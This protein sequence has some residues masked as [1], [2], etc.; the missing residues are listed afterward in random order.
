VTHFGV[1]PRDLA[2]AVSIHPVD[3]FA[4]T[5]EPY[6][7]AADQ[8]LRIDLLRENNRHSVARILRGLPWLGFDGFDST[9]LAFLLIDIQRSFTIDK[10]LAGA[11]GTLSRIFRFGGRARGWSVRRSLRQERAADI[12]HF[13]VFAS[14]F[15]DW[16]FEE[17]CHFVCIPRPIG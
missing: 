14:K 12:F 16:L 11:L 9:I 13:V 6:A 2:A 5:T 10:A 4:M 8:G 17:L 7:I 15:G 1:L 3:Y